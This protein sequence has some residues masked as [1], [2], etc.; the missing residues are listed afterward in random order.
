MRCAQ[1]VADEERDEDEALRQAIEALA[2]WVKMESERRGAKRATTEVLCR[3]DSGSGI[4]SSLS[5]A[6]S[7]ESSSEEALKAAAD[8]ASLIPKKRRSSTGEP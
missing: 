7:G 4:P 6:G 3:E 1:H 5:V 2:A 8:V